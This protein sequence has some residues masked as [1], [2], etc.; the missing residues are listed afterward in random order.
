MTYDKLEETLDLAHDASVSTSLADIKKALAEQNSKTEDVAEEL[1]DLSSDMTPVTQEAISKLAERENRVTEMIDL[2]DFD[3][4]TDELY[5]EALS[6]FKSTFSTAGAVEGRD[7]GKIYE[8]ACQFLK[9]ALDAKT[10]KITGRLNAIDA[11]LK[12]RRLDQYDN[13]KGDEDAAIDGDSKFVDRNEI[14]SSIKEQLE[15][16]LAKA[17]VNSKENNKKT[18]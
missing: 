8:A 15:S 12:K 2:H 6:A 13:K 17:N 11:A 4:S 10:A 16:S 18:K 1:D 3:S 5:V 7:A 9:T 14:L